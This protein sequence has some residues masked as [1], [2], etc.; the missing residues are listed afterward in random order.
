MPRIEPQINRMKDR[1]LI[2]SPGMLFM[3][4]YKYSL[5]VQGRINLTEY[6]QSVWVPLGSSSNYHDAA[7]YLLQSSRFLESV[8]KISM[9]T[10]GFQWLAVSKYCRLAQWVVK[11]GSL[12]VLE[13]DRLM[14]SRDNGLA[15]VLAVVMQGAVIFYRPQGLQFFWDYPP[16]R[17]H[18]EKW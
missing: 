9:L 3:V 18:C 13:P 2:A 10:A 14:I 6:P 15:C 5:V 4:I 17:P 16:V 1:W 11:S 8:Q 12:R 7:C